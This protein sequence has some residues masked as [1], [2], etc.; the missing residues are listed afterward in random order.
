MGLAYQRNALRRLLQPV[1]ARQG[2]AAAREELAP[3]PAM[4]EALDKELVALGGDVATDEN[5][6]FR[7][8]FP[9]ISEE[10]AAIEKARDQT[11]ARERD[12]GA[13]VFSSKE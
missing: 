12:P 10:L 8:V 5:G 7:Y 4:A 2:Q 11:S 3:D 13:I 1:L 9:H 6:K